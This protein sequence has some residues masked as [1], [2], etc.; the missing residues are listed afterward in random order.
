VPFL[1]LEKKWTY[2]AITDDEFVAAVKRIPNWK[3]PGI[4]LIHGY[5]LKNFTSVHRYLFYY[6]NQLIC[7]EVSPYPTL[8]AGRT[9]LLIKDKTKGLIP[10][11]YRPIT[12]LSA[13]WNL[14]LF[15]RNF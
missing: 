15:I 4:D 12:C 7:L 2:Y 13:I 9:S 1:L 14:G 10:S 3:S 6:F 8:L 11:N 5:W